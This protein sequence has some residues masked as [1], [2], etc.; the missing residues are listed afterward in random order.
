MIVWS[1]KPP[2]T[3]A[4]AFPGWARR[5]KATRAEWKGPRYGGHSRKAIGPA[6]GGG[7]LHLRLG[8]DQVSL[9]AAGDERGAVDSRTGAPGPGA[10][11]HAAQPPRV[12]RDPLRPLRHGRA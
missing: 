7:N 2:S 11:S 5:S 8:D 4:A 6:G 9:R 10:G 1:S 3:S 12:G